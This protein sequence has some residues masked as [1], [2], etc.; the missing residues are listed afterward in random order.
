[1]ISV[2]ECSAGKQVEIAREQLEYLY[3]QRFDLPLKYRDKLDARIR[4]WRRVLSYAQG[5]AARESG[6]HISRCM[7]LWAS[8]PQV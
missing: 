8:I 5:Q 1:M 2:C 3:N 4:A 6:Q 7:Q